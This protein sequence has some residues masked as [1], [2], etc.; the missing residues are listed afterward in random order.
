[1]QKFIHDL[2]NQKCRGIWKMRQVGTASWHMA[3]VPGSVYADLMRDGTLADPF[4][5]DNEFAAFD[6]MKHDWEYVSEFSVPAYVTQR[7]HILLRDPAYF[8]RMTQ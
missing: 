4:Y 1:M 7:Q 6:L 8:S 3:A 5:R 2:G